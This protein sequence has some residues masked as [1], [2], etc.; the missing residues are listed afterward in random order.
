M[1]LP[2]SL[3]ASAV[4]VTLKLHNPKNKAL[5]IDSIAY[6]IDTKDVGGVIEGSA[7]GGATIESDQTAELKFR[8]SIPF[9]KE[10]GAYRAILDRHTIPI[11]LHGTVKLSDGE[12]VAFEK[13]TEVATPSLPKFIV[14]DAQAARYQKEG[15]DVTLFLRLVNDNVF[16]VLVQ[17]VEYNVSIDA[18]QIKSEKAG[19]GVRLLPG[20]AEEYEVSSQLDQK[21]LDKERLRQILQTRKVEYKVTGKIELDRLTLPFEHTGTIELASGE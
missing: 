9:P 8:Q 13:N 16:P 4:E 6:S 3:D 15:I 1:P 18:K 5:R 21:S 12:S 17:G 7:E 14:H 19:I 20:G 11:I 2:E 10:E